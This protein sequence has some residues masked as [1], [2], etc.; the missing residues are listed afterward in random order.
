MA[1]AGSWRGDSE[2]APHSYGPRGSMIFHSFGHGKRP[3]LN[4]KCH[5]HYFEYLYKRTP[6]FSFIKVP[7]PQTDI[8]C[9]ILG[10]HVSYTRTVQQL[11]YVCACFRLLTG[12][13]QCCCCR[14]KSSKTFI[15]RLLRRLCLVTY[16]A[17]RTHIDCNLVQP[18]YRLSLLSRR[19]LMVHRPVVSNYSY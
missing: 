14:G 19:S 15:T 3:L 7:R 16:G 4:K 12:D 11:V 13:W 9:V 17:Y 10:L 5:R 18:I 2:P 8:V 1:E 6:G